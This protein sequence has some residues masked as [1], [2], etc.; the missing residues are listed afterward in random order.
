MSGKPSSHAL[1][2]GRSVSGD[3]LGMEVFVTHNL[4]HGFGATT[5]PTSENPQG[6]D[7]EKSKVSKEKTTGEIISSSFLNER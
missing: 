3:Q 6:N 5:K 4:L 1:P 2:Y 7:G